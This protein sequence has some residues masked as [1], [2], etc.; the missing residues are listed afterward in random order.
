[1]SVLE[2]DPR[3]LTPARPADV[4]PPV[5]NVVEECDTKGLHVLI[6]SPFGD[7]VGVVVWDGPAWDSATEFWAQGE[8]WADVAGD[9]QGIT[10]TAGRQDPDSLMLA[11][12]VVFSLDNRTGRYS[13]FVTDG[14][15]NLV[16]TGFLP[17]RRVVV[18][19]E[20][21]GVRYPRFVGKVESWEENLETVEGTPPKITVTAVDGFEELNRGR[22]SVEWRL[23]GEGDGPGPRINNLLD[24]GRWTG[25]RRLAMGDVNLRSITSTNPVLEEI[26]HTAVS[27]GGVA[28]IDTDGAFL[29]QDRRRINGRA[30]Q[31]HVPTFA[32][33][34][35]PG[36]YDFSAGD[37]VVDVDDIVNIVVS[38]NVDGVQVFHQDEASMAKYGAH[39]LALDGLLWTYYAQ[40]FAL[41]Q[42]IVSHRADLY[43]RYTTLALYPN[44]SNGLLAV[45]LDLR[46]G[47]RI[48]LERTMVDGSLLRSSLIVDGFAMSRLAQ[49]PYWTWA[50]YV[51]KGA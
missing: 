20:Y 28:V 35:A 42:W 50:L 5:A 3:T 33:D 16:S 7:P 29:Y 47:D 31:P 39:G 14:A 18:Y 51:S 1:M 46:I 24:V 25:A 2:R 43:Y 34:C 15:G 40:G 12:E 41:A 6:E 17:G 22:G 4:A 13:Q 48:V 38:A 10:I 30:D 37:P 23:G 9:V 8:F 44:E 21:L 27:D 49:G 11:A 32:D 36:T 45:A 19:V 26:H